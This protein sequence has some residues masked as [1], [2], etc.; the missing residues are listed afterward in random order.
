M[1][2]SADDI[3]HDNNDD[4]GDQAVVI[5]DSGLQ[6]DEN[7]AGEQETILQPN[8]IDDM[9][10]GD[11]KAYL[12]RYYYRPDTKTCEEFKYGGCRGNGNNFRSLKACEEFCITNNT[13][14]HEEPIIDVRVIRRS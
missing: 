1:V 6:G 10:K 7:D 8:C 5:G 14:L 9:D 2:A 3:D 4:E 13:K 12:T 11:C